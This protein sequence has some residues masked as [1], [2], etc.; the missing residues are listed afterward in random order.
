[1]GHGHSRPGHLLGTPL[2]LEDRLRKETKNFARIWL[3]IAKRGYEHK[4]A[5]PLS[6]TAFDYHWLFKEKTDVEFYEVKRSQVPQSYS[7]ILERALLTWNT[8]LI[9][10]YI[11]F[12]R[13]K[14]H[15]TSK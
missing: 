1:M 15:L 13:V 5:R 12:K 3:V 8:C 4:T 7:P 11:I 9:S 14:K 6:P 10:T 2:T